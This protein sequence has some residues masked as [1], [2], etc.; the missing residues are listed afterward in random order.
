MTHVAEFSRLSSGV[1]NL[2]TP[3]LE[4]VPATAG[5]VQAEIEGP[6]RLRRLLGA[7]VPEAWPP[8]DL[9]DALP[10]FQERLERQPEL[11]GWFSWYWVLMR[12][13]APPGA[14]PCRPGGRGGEAPVI[15]PRIAARVHA[16]AADGA[17]VLIGS[18]GS[19]GRPMM[20]GS[21]S[22]ITS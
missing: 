21:R 15:G 9:V 14:V 7:R 12:P 4:L 11:V 3:R 22:G 19:T 1:S 17:P 10:V 18:G 13:E 20:E 16:E 2:V 5:L 8:E 6:R